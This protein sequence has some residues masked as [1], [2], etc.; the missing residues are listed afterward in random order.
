MEHPVE[1]SASS[2]YEAAALALKEFRARRKFADYVGPASKTTL[3]VRVKPPGTVH[4]VQ[5]EQ[6]ECWLNSVGKPKEMGLKSRLK[7]LLDGSS[8][9]RYAAFCRGIPS[10]VP[11]ISQFL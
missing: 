1:V 7:T 3:R 4:E 11:I 9:S 10:G 5:V 8:V 2:L 6:V